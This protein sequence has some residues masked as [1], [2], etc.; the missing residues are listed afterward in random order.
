MS[1][2]LKGSICIL[3]GQWIYFNI[4]QPISLTMC[5]FNEGSEMINLEYEAAPSAPP[6]NLGRAYRRI[7]GILEHGR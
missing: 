2:S 4:M 5:Y 7:A 1:Q 3:G 6:L